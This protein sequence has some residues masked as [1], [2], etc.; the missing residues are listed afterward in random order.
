MIKH[1]LQRDTHIFW[2]A[3]IVGAI[4]VLVAHLLLSVIGSMLGV[5]AL[6][7]LH[8]A[9]PLSGLGAGTAIWLALTV[10]F[11]F[12]VGGL[13]VSRMIAS[14][15]SEDGLLHGLLT[16]G[17]AS[18]VGLL[19]VMAMVGRGFRRIPVLC[20]Q[21]LELA[22]LIQNRILPTS[23]YGNSL[24]LPSKHQRKIS[25]F[26]KWV[27][28]ATK[29]KH[30]LIPGSIVGDIPLALHLVQERFVCHKSV[31]GAWLV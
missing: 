15:G 3:I 25:W 9:N 31:F 13:I 21:C 23:P 2:G 14:R 10:M 27:T 24:I 7:P 12:F 28:H 22:T 5:S 29:Q 26:R 19:L 16:W 18:A 20:A 8:E 30:L 6:D 1:Y 17:I 4:I 11:S